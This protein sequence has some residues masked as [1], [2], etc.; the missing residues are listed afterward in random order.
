MKELWNGLA[1]ILVAIGAGLLAISAGAHAWNYW[2]SPLF[3]RGADVG[4]G[5]LVGFLGPLWLVGLPVTA[6]GALLWATLR[7]RNTHNHRSRRNA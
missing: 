4:A 7:T 3:S 1:A 2:L 5:L 6:V